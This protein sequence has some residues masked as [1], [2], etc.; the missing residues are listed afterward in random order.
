MRLRE[1]PVCFDKNDPVSMGS[2]CA[3]I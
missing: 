3:V 2:T 1:L